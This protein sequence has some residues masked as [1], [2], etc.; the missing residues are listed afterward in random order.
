MY[1][2]DD[3]LLS[4]NN[5]H[6]SKNKVTYF[7]DLVVCC[8]NIEKVKYRGWERYRINAKIISGQ[9]L[10]P[11]ESQYMSESVEQIKI[12]SYKLLYLHLLRHLP[13]V[14]MFPLLMMHCVPFRNKTD[15]IKAKVR[16]NNRVRLT[17]CNG[18]ISKLCCGRKF[19]CKENLACSAVS[20]CKSV[21]LI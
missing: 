3:M 6:L 2:L 10:L 17:I 8:N 15:I 1:L 12:M 21:Y 14:S 11:K 20:V 5:G 16:N 7:K 13:S 18:S 9:I 4:L 19:V